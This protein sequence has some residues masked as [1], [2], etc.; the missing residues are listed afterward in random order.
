MDEC[1]FNELTKRVARAGTRRGVLG[2]VAAGLTAPA[3]GALGYGYVAAQDVEGEAFGFCR[4]GGFPCGSNEQCCT[5]RCLA[6]GVC[7]CAKRGKSCINRVGANCCSR[8]CRKGK[9]K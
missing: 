2:A 7:D 3:L 8:K 4:I 6:T 5:G 1:G 9:C